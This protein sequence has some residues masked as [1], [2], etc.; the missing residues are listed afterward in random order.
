M[1]R[2]IKFMVF[3]FFYN[4]SLFGNS[5]IFQKDFENKTIFIEKNSFKILNF[6]KQVKKVQL[7]NSTILQAEFENS[8]NEVFR[9]LKIFAKKAGNENALISFVD[10]TVIQISFNIVNNLKDIID[11]IK[12][13][14][15]NV[16]IKQINKTIVLEGTLNSEKEKD[17]IITILEKI[18]PK[19]KDKL[20]NVVKINKPAKMIRVKLYA[21]EIN[22][23]KGLTLKN[24]W[25][26][27]RK[28]YMKVTNSSNSSL[29]ANV[30]LQDTSFG[31][32]N[33]QRN[34]GVEETL[35]QIMANAVTLTGGLTGTAN[36]LSDKFNVGL[37]LNYLSEKGIANILDETTLIT[38]EKE[39]SKFHAGGTIYLKLQSS[40]SEG[41]PTSE[42]KNINY[43]LQLNIKVKN[44]LNKEFVQLHINTKSTQID[45]SNEVDG[46]P[47]FLDKSINTHVIV[48]NNATIVLGGLMKNRSSEDIDKIP[49]LGDIPI[50]G[51]LFKSRAFKEGKSELVFFITPEIVDPI[52][53][54]QK[55]IK[56]E[57]EKLM[58]KIK[59]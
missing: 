49:L 56:I 7:S 6:D 28:N 41:L 2:I 35:N 34:F 51:Y 38:L 48:K 42:M 44:I 43:G 31:K 29:Y 59:E 33:N 18:D 17:E 46:I 19:I 8:N 9:R 24:N 25:F 58:E 39:E 26:I 23:E 13:K 54:N 52:I 27:S 57:K 11:V 5:E 47:N 53:N 3:I 12:K 21:V 40:T 16:Q 37:T 4:I 30:P 14:Y 10:N 22:N 50:L 32:V 20:I 45:W 36:F 55:N 15:P 1:I